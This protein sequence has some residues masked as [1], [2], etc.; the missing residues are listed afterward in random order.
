MGKYR[1]I[2]RPLKGQDKLVFDKMGNGM[3][4]RDVNNL[5]F[6]TVKGTISKKKKKT[7]PDQRH[8]FESLLRNSDRKHDALR[9]SDV[10]KIQFVF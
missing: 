9:K 5:N 6:M 8:N 10:H 1:K 2:S 3:K 7:L 4:V